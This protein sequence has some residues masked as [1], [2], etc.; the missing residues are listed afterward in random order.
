VALELQLV[1]LKERLAAARVALEAALKAK[2]GKKGAPDPP[3][4]AEARHDKYRY[5]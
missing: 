3:E 1:D 5:T 2:K 4:A